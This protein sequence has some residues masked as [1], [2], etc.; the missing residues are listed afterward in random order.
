[1]SAERTRR[2][3]TSGPI[4]RT[5][6][7]FSLPTLGSNVLQSLNGSVNAAW[8]GHFLGPAALS[9][10]SNANLILFFLLGTVFGIGMAATILVGQAVGARDIT[11]AKQI[12]GTGLTFYVV[13]SLAVSLAGYVFT[14]HILSAMHTPPDARPL[15]IAYLRVIFVALPFLNLL[16]FASMVLRGAGD[17]RTPFMLMGL[18][19]VLD[20]GL[21]PLLIFGIG[22]FHGFGIMG[23]ALA[24]LTA[25]VIGIAALWLLL[26]RRRHF[27][28]LH[29]HEFGMLRPSGAIMHALVFKGFPMG[30]QML[31][32]SLAG[33]AMIGMVNTFGTA[34]TA[35]YGAVTQLWTYVQMPAVAVGASVSSMVAQNVG[36][37]RWDRVSRITRYGVL[38]SIVMTALPTVVILT[39]SRAAL[40]LFLGNDAHAIAIGMHI[41]TIAI[42][43]FTLFGIMFVLAGTVRA[44]GAVVPPLLLL[45]FSLWGVRIP[46]ARALLPIY[47]AEAIWWSFP[48]GMIVA[49]TL[50]GLYYKFGRWRRSTMLETDAATG[51]AASVQPP[52]T[53]TPPVAP[54]AAAASP[55]IASEG[56]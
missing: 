21:N 44:T 19:V 33:I 11:R 38:F 50:V 53:S 32:I 46:F 9:A 28:L 54:A 48:L 22:P 29:P 14:P 43:T 56:R 34:T 24:T 20:G 7:K 42:G 16:G 27:L 25:Q 31:V 30:L 3:L 10:A 6:L 45:T 49:V 23:S 55:A 4:G 5:L 18:T 47:G 17:S 36:A 1:M 2:D 13:V 8:I 39:F 15:A 51:N 26:H 37:R 52:S 35:A 12:V 41:N 40:G